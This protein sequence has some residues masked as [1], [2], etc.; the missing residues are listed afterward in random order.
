VGIKDAF[1]GV[2]N[3]AYKTYGEGVPPGGEQFDRSAQLQKMQQA[4]LAAGPDDR[5]QGSGSEAYGRAN[6]QL[7]DRYGE[8]ADLDRRYGAEIDKSKA[9]VLAGRQAMLTVRSNFDALVSGLDE[10]KPA[11]RLLLMSAL[12]NGLGEVQKTLLNTTQ[13]QLA[14]GQRMKVIADEYAAEGKPKVAGGEGAGDKPDDKGKDEKKPELKPDEMEGLV[15]DALAGNQEAAAKVNDILNSIDDKSL[16]PKN[17]EPPVPLSPVQE[18]LVGQMQ[19][20]MKSMSMNDLKAAGE[21]L[22]PQKNILANAMQVMSDPDVKYQRQDGERPKIVPGAGSAVAHGATVL[23]GDRGALPDGVQSAL[24]QGGKFDGPPH[25]GPVPRG[26]VPDTEGPSR[27]SAMDNLSSLSDIVGSGDQK[28]Q[29]GTEL[30]RGMMSNAK[31]FL[32]SQEGPNNSQEHWGD[33]TIQ[34]V[35]ET[36]GRDTIVSHDML[37][38]NKDFVHDVLTHEWNDNGRSA[39]TLTNWI[40]G[41]SHSSDQ[42]I[43]RR[44][45]ET[46]SALAD[47]LGDPENKAALMDISNASERDISLGKLNPEL[48]QSLAHAISPYL[49]DMV[50]KNIDDTLGFTTKDG[51]HNMRYPHASQVLGVLGTDDGAAKILD[52]RAA[53]VQGKYLDEYTKSVVDSGGNTSAAAAM[54]AAGRLKG[55]WDEGAFMSVSDVEHDS[56]KARQMAWDR[57]ATNYDIAKDSIG[58]LP[59]IGTVSGVGFDVAKDAVLGSRPESGGSESTPIQSSMPMK[60]ML[61]AALIS[62]NMGDPADI[63]ALDRFRDKFTGDIYVPPHSNENSD[64]TDFD[65]AIS[66][67]FSHLTSAVKDPVNIQYDQAY[68]DATSK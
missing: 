45:G 3:E 20:Q 59:Y 14:A 31:D 32:N 51:D 1:Y 4:V 23:P 52:G 34:R 16:Q 38:G 40:E 27:R 29:Q 22:G 33:K 63:A 58:A 24:N 62:H 12:S 35:F 36:A 64:R 66:N 47:Y 7:A 44:A 53:E 28:F 61:A 30:D 9:A 25:Q 18:A 19:A 5:W 54:E 50:N 56:V 49:D 48:T 67:Y 41:A 42:D 6:K 17:G 2:W 8:L 68:R 65:S 10:N 55:V 11:D 60:T 26:H 15:K 13:E 43:N 21:R 37:T 57:M 39:S 46:A